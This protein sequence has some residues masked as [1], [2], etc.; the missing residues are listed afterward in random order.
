MKILI[1]RPHYFQLIK[2]KLHKTPQE[3]CFFIKRTLFVD[4]IY[5]FNINDYLKLLT[6]SKN[7][8][9]KNY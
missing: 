9:I 6:M 3:R 1:I 4:H 2:L 7:I 5:F 8:Y